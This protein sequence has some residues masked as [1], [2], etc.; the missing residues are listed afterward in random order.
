MSVSVGLSHFAHLVRRF[1]GYLT[2]RPLDASERDEV[3]GLLTSELAELFFEMQHQ[4]QRH[5]VE[6]YRR[7]GSEELAQAALL[8]DVGKSISGIGPINRSLATIAG[9]LHLPLRASWHLYLDHGEIGAD[10][11]DQAGA[12]HLTVSF[13]RNHPG[14]VPQGIDAEAWDRLTRADEG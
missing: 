12:D 10:L 4:D 1:V 6:V 14:P 3:A 8:H 13:A 11:L 2:A 9:A 5:A 7:V